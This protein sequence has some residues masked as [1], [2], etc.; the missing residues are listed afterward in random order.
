[1]ECTQ[2]GEYLIKLHDRTV[3]YVFSKFYCGNNCV[4]KEATF[5]KIDDKHKLRV[6]LYI[7]KVLKHNQ[8]PSLQNNLDILYSGH[9]HASR[10]GDQLVL[11]VFYQS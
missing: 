4:F 10:S 1:M 9:D 11:P 2:R 5:S 6:A 8:Y 7:F 3:R